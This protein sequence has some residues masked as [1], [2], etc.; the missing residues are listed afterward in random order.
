MVLL[1]WQ[2]TM[3]ILLIKNLKKAREILNK[4]LQAYVT[5]VDFLAEFMGENTEVV[6]H[7]MTDWHHSVIAIRNGHI[8]GRKVG[9]PITETNLRILRS[10]VHKKVPYM[11]NDPKKFKKNI[12]LKEQFII[13]LFCKNNL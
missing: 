7:D 6:L 1:V 4:K 2:I 8:S 13:L 9:D 10:E 5:L 11:N 3:G 12:L